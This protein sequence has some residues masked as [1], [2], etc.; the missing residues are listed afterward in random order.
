[1]AGIRGAVNLLLEEQDRIYQK[2]C[3]T[4]LCIPPVPTVRAHSPERVFG[5]KPMGLV[6]LHGPLWGL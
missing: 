1:M 4:I 3:S 2:V 5:D 6:S